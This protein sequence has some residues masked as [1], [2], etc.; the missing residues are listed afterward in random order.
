[1][2]A[3]VANAAAAL[4]GGCIDDDEPMNCTGIRIED[5]FATLQ[6]EGTVNRVNA[7][8]DGEREVKP[9]QFSPVF[10]RREPDINIG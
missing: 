6:T 1:M 4:P 7:I 5:D 9:G 3:P 2:H 8:T 10:L